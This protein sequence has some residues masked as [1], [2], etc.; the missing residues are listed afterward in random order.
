MH[1]AEDILVASTF[2][3]YALLVGKHGDVVFHQEEM[4][5][6]MLQ[7]PQDMLNFLMKA[8]EYMVRAISHIWAARNNTL[9]SS[10]SV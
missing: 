5:I 9:S 10:S 4:K 3:P 8:Q 7:E 2:Y 1:Q 6:M